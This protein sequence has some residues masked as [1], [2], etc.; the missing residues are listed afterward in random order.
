MTLTIQVEDRISEKYADLSAKLQAAADYVVE[1]PTDVATRSLRAVSAASGVSPATLSRLARTLEFESYED[2]REL[3]RGAVES[4]GGSF[5]ERAERLKELGD[6]GLSMLDRQTSACVLNISAMTERIDRARLKS[7][8]DALEQARKVVLFGAFSSTGVVEYMAYLANFFKSNWM[9]ADRMGASLG[10]TLNGLGK[11]D[12]ILIVTKTPYAR[13]AV[14]AAEMVHA[15]GAQVIVITD[16][17][18]CPANKFAHFSFIVPSD[19]PQFFS[20]YAATI[21]LL[22]TM[23]AML[24]A[25][26][27][28]TTSERIRDIE[29]RNTSLGEFWAD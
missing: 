24:V 7:A 15:A 13:R 27:D 16:S 8:V 12:V 25:R 18:A 23:I 28:A 26:S 29:A 2:M 11:D 19:S 4:R 5:A 3:L 9:L 6:S 22:E 10:A 1:N 21:A 20:S 17:H 14:L